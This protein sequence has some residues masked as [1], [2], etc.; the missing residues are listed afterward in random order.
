VICAGCREGDHE[1]CLD[2][3]LPAET[4]RKCDC[5]H[6][7]EGVNWQLVQQKNKERAGARLLPSLTAQCGYG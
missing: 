2:G 7:H 5:Q 4:G 3:P 6:E 1:A